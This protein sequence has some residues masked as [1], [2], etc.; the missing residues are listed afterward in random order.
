MRERRRLLIA[1][2]EKF[3]SI[4]CLT[5]TSSWDW[6][7]QASPGYTVCQVINLNESFANKAETFSLLYDLPVP[8]RGATC[9]S[10]LRTVK[11]ASTSSYCR[12]PK[13]LL[14]R[15]Q[16]R[17]PLPQLGSACCVHCLVFEFRQRFRHWARR[18][19]RNLAVRVVHIKQLRKSLGVVMR[20]E[21]PVKLGDKIFS[22]WV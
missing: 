7:P 20:T 10:K 2:I 11:V 21:F 22:R 12:H 6:T 1:P 13:L 8:E 19:S 18:F 16:V 4:I 9:C 3:P 17:Y 15:K 14:W 5:T